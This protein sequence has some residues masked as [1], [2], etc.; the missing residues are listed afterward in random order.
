MRIGAPAEREDGE[1]RV[2]LTPEACKKLVG[3]G[4]EVVVERGAGAEAGHLDPAYEQAGAEIVDAATAWSAPLV[5]RINPLTLEDVARLSEGAT[6]IGLLYAHARPEVVDAL[7]ARK[8]TFLAL[9]RIPRSTIA[10]SFD[11]LSSMANI[12]GYRAVIEAAAELGT[13]LGPQMTAAG[14]KPPARVLVIGAGVAG[15]AAIGAARALGAEVRAFDTRDAV[16][17]E[18]SSLGATFLELDFEETGDGGGGYAK[19]MSEAFIE[20]EMALFLA[21]APEVD[22]VIT[23]ALIPARPA[24]RLWTT[25]HVEAMK[26]G[27]VVVDLAAIQGGNCDETVPGEKAQH[28]G[29]TILGY[30]DLVSRMAGDASRFF[31][32]NLVN[33]LKFAGKGL[34]RGELALTPEDTT[35]G[36][37]LVLVDGVEPPPPPP[38]PPAARRP[39][40]PRH[41]PVVEPQVPAPQSRTRDALLSLGAAVGLFALGVNAPSELV[42]H[43]TVFVLACFVGWQVIWN[44]SPALHTPLMAV[45]NAISGIILVGGMLQAGLGSTSWATALGG[46]AILLATINVVGGFMVTQRMLAMFRKEG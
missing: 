35:L 10:Q 39:E 8:V 41:A 23:T 13:F 18:V 27:S 38:A 19:V 37:A 34:E 20:A 44:V 36:P 26:P 4:H 1:R 29:V 24:P 7:A 11:V 25:E 15:L 42:G 31:A 14:K 2:V 30:T 28:A 33:L 45:T 17:D 16:K 40:P 46:V 12:A 3:L 21:Q 9:E 43:L 22:I 5:L 32:N 6:V